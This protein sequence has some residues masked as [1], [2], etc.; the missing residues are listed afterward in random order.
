MNQKKLYM[1]KE[2]DDGPESM[3]MDN[4]G[5]HS[6]RIATD[7]DITLVELS[8]VLDRDA[9]NK[10]NHDFVGCHFNLAML[11]ENQVGNSEATKIM[12]KIVDAGG[13]HGMNR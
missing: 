5:Y 10:N 3:K 9:E 13:L 11:L 7:K 4:E 2:S 1:V 8:D 6:S 12:R